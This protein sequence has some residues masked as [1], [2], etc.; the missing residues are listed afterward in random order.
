LK[1]FTCRAN[2]HHGV[3][4]RAKFGDGYDDGAGCRGSRLFH[5]VGQDRESGREDGTLTRSTSI[6]TP[7]TVSTSESAG[8]RSQQ[9]QQQQQLTFAYGFQ[10]TRRPKVEGQL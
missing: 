7:L 5:G 2:R 4:E 10:T 6:E 9:Q 3:V 1:T 8:Q